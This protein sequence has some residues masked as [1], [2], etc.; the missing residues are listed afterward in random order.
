MT[1]LTGKNIKA[2]KNGF[3]YADDSTEKSKNVIGRILEYHGKNSSRDGMYSVIC[4]IGDE[5]TIF[6]VPV[7]YPIGIKGA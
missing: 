7:F 3:L 6:Q 4:A 2:F 5:G 1:N